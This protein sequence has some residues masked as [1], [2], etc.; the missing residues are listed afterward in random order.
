MPSP[1]EYAA[2]R[3]KAEIQRI[4]RTPLRGT[5]LPGPAPNRAAFRGQAMHDPRGREAPAG[6]RFDSAEAQ[7]EAPALS[8]C[9]G[10]DILT[11]PLSRRG[12]EPQL[13][14]RPFWS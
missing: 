11:R 12:V 14:S 3:L 6:R 9:P 4:R 5:R 7:T 2:N 13:L 10:V 1:A 8:P